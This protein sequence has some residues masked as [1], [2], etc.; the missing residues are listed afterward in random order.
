MKRFLI[1]YVK[2]LAILA[3]AVLAVGC[4][5]QKRLEAENRLLKEQVKHLSDALASGD[6]S[7]M[8]LSDENA[9]LA[10]D[11]AKARAALA[12]KDSELDEMSKRLAAKGFDVSVSEGTIT[13]TLPAKILYASG[14]AIITSSGKKKL[15][16]LAT[17]LNKEF[18]DFEIEIQGHTD[19]DPIKKTKGKYESNWELSHT[20]AQNVLYYLVKSGRIKP[21][22]IHASAYG[23]YHPTASNASSAGKSKNRRVEIAL[24]KSAK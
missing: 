6:S 9:Q 19:N 15:K 14:S 23:E 24:S 5:S 16:T 13:V 11:L 2:P 20:R 10:D 12:A 7:A 4:V 3:V 8:G 21:Q 1:S 17:E 18:A 22:R